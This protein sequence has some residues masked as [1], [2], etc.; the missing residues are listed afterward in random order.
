MATGAGIDVMA[1]LSVS[2]IDFNFKGLSILAGGL[3][4]DQD[5][6][7]PDFGHRL[8]SHQDIRR[9]ASWPELRGPAFPSKD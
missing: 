1:W 9:W 5:R 4:Q 8:L 6:R 2:K 3:F 7:Q